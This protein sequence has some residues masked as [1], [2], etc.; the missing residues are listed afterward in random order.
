ML[1]ILVLTVARIYQLVVP[2]VHYYVYYETTVVAFQQTAVF[3][4][5]LILKQTLVKSVLLT[6]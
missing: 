6:S 3:E 5:V 4:S 1:L 2:T